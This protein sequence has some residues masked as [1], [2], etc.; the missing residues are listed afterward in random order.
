MD[1]MP[2]SKSLW[3][4]HYAQKMNWP[5]VPL[6]EVKD[7]C[8]TCAA[9]KECG[10]RSG[11][12]P[13][14]KNGVHNATTDPEQIRRWWRQWP[15]ANIGVATGRISDIIVIDVDPRNGGNRTAKALQKEL[16]R[17][18]RSL[19]ARLGG[20]GAH[21]IC[22]YPD[23]DVRSDRLGKLLGPGIDILSDGCHFVAPESEH[24]SGWLYSWFKDQ[25]PDKVKPPIFRKL[26]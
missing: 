1:A 18:P 19:K 22:K 23:F 13:R 3:A 25:S 21:Y 10:K 16:G 15:S 12:H 14:T 24:L 6:F 8:C 20:G 4:L 26:G 11:K 9:G 17:L 2:K 7:G 5:V